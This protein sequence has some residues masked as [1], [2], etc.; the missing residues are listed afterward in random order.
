M[1]MTLRLPDEL[2]QRVKQNAK[3]AGVSVN[4][5][6]V[7]ALDALD[8][9]QSMVMFYIK[10][11]AIGDFNANDNCDFCNNQL[12]QPH[13]AFYANGMSAIVCVDCA[14]SHSGV[15]NRR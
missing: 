11:D 10:I 8:D 5:Y 1:N 14:E 6:I 15:E 3:L 4:Q 13:A 7:D 12:N 2:H 9:V